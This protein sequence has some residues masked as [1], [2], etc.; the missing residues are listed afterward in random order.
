MSVHVVNRLAWKQIPPFQHLNSPHHCVT[1]DGHKHPVTRS[2]G[3][4]LQNG[5][6]H[7]VYPYSQSATGRM[8]VM[9]RRLIVAYDSMLCTSVGKRLCYGDY[10]FSLVHT[11][12][13]P[14]G[15]STLQC[16]MRGQPVAHIIFFTRSTMRLLSQWQWRSIKISNYY[17]YYYILLLTT[18]NDVGKDYNLTFCWPDALFSSSRPPPLPHLP[19]PSLLATDQH[20]DHQHG[21]DGA[22]ALLPGAVPEPGQATA[23]GGPHG[24]REE[25]HHQQL[26]AGAAARQVHHQQHQLLRADL[27]QPDAGHH[28]L[29]ARQVRGWAFHVVFFLIGVI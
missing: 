23:A 3:S 12:G 7:A 27:R 22:S 11:H 28:L 29:Q 2:R 5:W 1:G 9:T 8:A 17:Y 20:P 10:T 25:R 19:P 26:P 14:S 4:T 24:H 13:W 15:V 18:C 6:K 16:C 21:G